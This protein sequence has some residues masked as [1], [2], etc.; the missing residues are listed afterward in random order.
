MRLRGRFIA[1]ESI[2]DSW[3][4]YEIIEEY[5]TDKYLPSYL[6]HSEYRGETFHVLFAV[7]VE[8]DSVRVVTAYRPSAEDWEDD[9]KRRRRSS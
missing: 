1:R 8:G 9:F 5:R 4:R 7:D 3:A 2:L 6:V